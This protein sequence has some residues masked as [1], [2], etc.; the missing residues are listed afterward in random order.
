MEAPRANRSLKDLI[1][2][3]RLAAHLTSLE[4]INCP[5]IE[6]MMSQTLV[7]DLRETLA[8]VLNACKALQELKLDV[9]SWNIGARDLFEAVLKLTSLRSLHVSYPVSA[10]Y[11]MS[12]PTAKL[13]E[14]S[15]RLQ[16]LRGLDGIFLEESI[17]VLDMRGAHRCV[18]DEVAT[19]TRLKATLC[20][21]IRAEGC[22]PLSN[23]TALEVLGLQ[24]DFDMPLRGQG[25]LQLF[26]QL[27]RLR[28]LELSFRCNRSS[29]N[30]DSWMI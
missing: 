12:W 2:N 29:V 25:G 7:W 22:A 27:S 3:L 23:L 26:S 6:S 24:L 14:I 19:H 16:H 28:E 17:D 9:N 30:F 20:C 10:I 15:H 18:V 11:P 1:P 5:W 8:C 13:F 4:L 21:N